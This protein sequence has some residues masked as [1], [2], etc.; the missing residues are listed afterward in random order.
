MFFLNHKRIIFIRA[1][2]GIILP[3]IVIFLGLEGGVCHKIYK[4]AR[5]SL[6][7][8]NLIA[9]LF[10]VVVASVANANP[11]VKEDLC[12]GVFKNLAV[13]KMHEL[14]EEAVKETEQ[15]MAEYSEILARRN[16]AEFNERSV[17]QSPVTANGPKAPLEKRKSAFVRFGKRS[18]EASS[19]L[20]PEDS[21][22]ADLPNVS[23]N[24]D[25]LTAFNNN[26]QFAS[27][28]KYLEISDINKRKSSYVRFG[29]R[30][31]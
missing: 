30:G 25:S 27:I 8:M 13:C 19:R 16:F 4:D 22:S 18:D 10:L 24:P 7:T 11:L 26:P 12:S 20:N 23:P 3:P 14:A 17:E 31:M 29:K 1:V 2:C 21:L 28:D 6:I 9:I 5:E 15:I